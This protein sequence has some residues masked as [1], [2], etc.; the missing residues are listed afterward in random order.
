MPKR[1]SYEAGPIGQV[2]NNTYRVERLIGRGGIGVVYEASHLRLVRRFAIKMLWGEL[3]KHPDDLGRFK[4][5]ALITSAL[6]HPHILE[7]MDFNRTDDGL[8]YLVMELLSGEDLGQRLNRVSRLPL[9]QAAGIFEQAASALEAVHGKGIIHR[10]LKPKNIFLCRRGERDDFVKIVD[11]G[12]SKVIGWRSLMTATHGLPGTPNYMTPEQAEQ[13]ASEMSVRSDVYAMG[14]ILWVMLAGGL[15][16][17]AESTEKV[18]YKIAHLEPPPLSAVNPEVPRSVAVV[19][20][21]AMRKRQEDRFGSMREFWQE[22]EAAL[23]REAVEITKPPDRTIWARPDPDNT[24]PPGPEQPIIRLPSDPTTNDTA[25]DPQP[26]TGVD[27]VTAKT[28]SL[29]PADSGKTAALDVAVTT[30][31]RSLDGEVSV[32]SLPPAASEVMKA[33]AAAR[34]KRVITWAG[35]LAALLVAILLIKV[36]RDSR[37]APD[38]LPSGRKVGAVAAVGQ[39]LLVLVMQP[40]ATLDPVHAHTHEEANIITQTHEGL[41]RYDAVRGQVL[42]A[43]ATSWRRE[44]AVY[45]FELREGVRFHDGSP[46]TATAVAESL[47]RSRRPRWGRSPLWDLEEVSTPGPSTVKLRLSRPSASLLARLTTYSCFVSAPARDG[48]SPL[49]TGPFKATAWNRQVGAVTLAPNPHYWGGAPRLRSITFRSEPDAEARA[50]VMI[51]GDAQIV[52]AL[53]PLV[54]RKLE[55]HRELS[56]LRSAQFMTVYLSFNTEKPYL[57]DP[58]VRR[59]LA[60]ALDRG[61]LVKKL[62]QDRATVAPASVP[63]TLLHHEVASLVRFDPA[64]AR[65]LLAGTGLADQPLRLYLWR[66]PRPYLPDPELA[67]RLLVRSLQAVG[68]KVKPILV[69]F[70]ELNDEVCGKQKLHDLVVFG[71]SPAYPDAENIYWQLTREGY[72]CARFPDARFQELF[73]RASA[74]QDAAKRDAL[75][76]ELEAL[77][78][79]SRPWLPLA[80]VAD[81]IAVR[82]EVRGYQYGFSF[83]NLLWLK[84]AFLQR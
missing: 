20:S 70:D 62:Y 68:L 30:K 54:A 12:I 77:I 59:A 8:P 67:G 2:L 35:A 60:M 15:P 57:R 3:A 83:I 28:P 17:S 81:H 44:G 7:V 79:R 42:P 75:F 80:H 32:P 84:D 56:V 9:G 22:L 48:P 34:R 5:E 63:P 53:P 29:D 26:R 73:D 43:L 10:D 51:E 58:A 6:G 27:G 18:I 61:E 55:Q 13:R 64:E 47:R 69:G 71:W 46:L 40:V 41:V 45:S 65:S 31:H 74:E 49:G 25:R 78:A 39:D 19:I 50:S 36:A 16:F 11:F 14:T 66:A 76:L 4:R 37:R 72:S 21:K 24:Q 1:P 82:G 38:A 52:M 33:S 23:R